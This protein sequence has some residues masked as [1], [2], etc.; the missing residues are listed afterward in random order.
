MNH[1]YN[2]GTS[3]LHLCLDDFSSVPGKAS[4]NWKTKF[5]QYLCLWEWCM[6]AALPTSFRINVLPTILVSFLVPLFVRV[7][8]ANSAPYILPSL[9]PSDNPRAFV[10][11]GGVCKQ[12]SLHPSKLMSFRQSSYLCL[13]EWC[14]QTVLPTSFRINVLPTIFVILLAWWNW[15]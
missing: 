14:M 13:W 12:R 15:A 1:T 8:Y 11:E 3:R 6:Q 5:T 9:C 2:K 4:S 7:V 10:C